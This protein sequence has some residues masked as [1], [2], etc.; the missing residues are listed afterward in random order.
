MLVISSTINGKQLPSFS[1]DDSLVNVTYRIPK[2]IKNN[3]E[4]YEHN[5]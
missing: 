5:I 1:T 4:H 2:Q 3:N